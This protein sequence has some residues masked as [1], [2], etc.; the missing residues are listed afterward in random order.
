[1][2]VHAI[3][4]LRIKPNPEIAR[5]K[6]AVQIFPAS[7]SILESFAIVN[8]F[9]K[10]DEQF[11]FLKPI[12][13]PDD[14][15]YPANTNFEMVEVWVE[16]RTLLSGPSDKRTQRVFVHQHNV[17]LVEGLL[18]GVELVTEFEN[19]RADLVFFGDNLPVLEKLLQSEVKITYS[20]EAFGSLAHYA[21]LRGSIS[22]I[23][24]LLRYGVDVNGVD[25][26][27]H[28]AL[29]IAVKAKHL[30]M[31]KAL[32]ANGSN[33]NALTPSGSSALHLAAELKFSNAV[34]A[35][36]E[37][38]AAAHVTDSSGRTPF[39]LAW[40]RYDVVSMEVL[41]KNMNFGAVA[42]TPKLLCRAVA[43]NAFVLVQ[44]LLENGADPN[45]VHESKAPY[46]Y[47]SSL[48]LGAIDTTAVHVACAFSDTK[49]IELLL[50][51][52]ADLNIECRIE[53][54][55]QRRRNSPIAIAVYRRK[56]GI[57]EF[58]LEEGATVYNHSELLDLANPYEKNSWL[59]DVLLKNGCDVNFKDPIRFL[60]KPIE[61]AFRSG[62]TLGVDTVMQYG[63][64][65]N[66]C[67]LLSHFR[68]DT[69][70]GHEFLMHFLSYGF[71]ELEGNSKLKVSHV[72]SRVARS[73]GTSDE[74]DDPD[75]PDDPLYLSVETNGLCQ[76]VLSEHLIKLKVAGKEVDDDIISYDVRSEFHLDAFEAD[77][78]AEFERVK[79]TI[80]PGTSVSCFKVL[81]QN[82]IAVSRYFRNEATRLA[83]TK[84]EFQREFPIYG[85]IIQCRVRLANWRREFFNNAVE[86]LNQSTI[87]LKL[88]IEV[89]ENI[90]DNLSVQDLIKLHVAFR[91][92]H[93]S[94]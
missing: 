88:P 41:F 48:R 47:P 76:Q 79:V 73:H 43:R 8:P 22:L 24:L 9:W 60:E 40:D 3:I 72:L 89:L 25:S 90:L 65:F 51:Y 74:S 13:G 29:H 66:Y 28:T 20:N 30:G 38:G 54:S 10:K 70:D 2:L 34:M 85:S 80:V 44:K 1:M 12:H 77:C 5:S 87:R 31:V 19:P 6:K 67:V 37:H 59:L 21:A 32:L 56:R 63:A 86:S 64:S 91:R 78:K 58:L 46:A 83:L 92:I 61:I 84:Y 81:T 36:I 71:T 33:P 55:S 82:T 14:V 4:F 62:I 93:A 57:V 75:D 17:D 23:P 26:D 18:P 68:G 53:K 16:A 15:N 69:Y 50:A 7:E 94:T 42:E 52:G 45:E 39:L 35:L 49:M 11:R 27:G